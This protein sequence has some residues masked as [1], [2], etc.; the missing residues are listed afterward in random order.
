MARTRQAATL[1]RV[2]DSER[3]FSSYLSVCAIYRDEARYMPEWIEFH[4]LFGVERFYLFNNR[5]SDDHLAVLSPYME[6]G[7]VVWRDWPLFPGQLQ[8]YAACLAEHGDESRWIAFI[9]L[10]EFLFAPEGRLLR[11][12]LHDFEAHPAVV[13]NM[14]YYGTSGHQ[15]PPAGLVI[16]NYTRRLR[17]D[18]PRNRAVKS[19]VDPQRTQQ[20]GY[21]SHYFVYADDAAAVDEHHRPARGH[22]TERASVERLR[23]NHYLTRSQQERDVK[24]TRLGADTGLPVQNL[25]TVEQRD[26]RLNE[27]VDEI[28]VPYGRAVRAA[29]DARA[30]GSPLPPG[31]LQTALQAG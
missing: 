29:L 26:R 7:T 6:D 16:E 25:D 3:N 13:A 14:V 10:D 15:T 4:R 5:S 2:K 20:P 19:I 21:V 11:D 17:L 27:E 22:A 31:S 12:V 18:R 28:L 9:D 23:I 24:L 30:A 8:A 1:Q